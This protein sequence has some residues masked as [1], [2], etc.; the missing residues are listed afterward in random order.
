MMD[1][2]YGQLDS[3]M[4]NTP[5]PRA[6]YGFS[7]DKHQGKYEIKLD[8]VVSADSSPRFKSI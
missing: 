1:T 8:G 3:T 2:T 4:K 6:Y 7:S 5:D